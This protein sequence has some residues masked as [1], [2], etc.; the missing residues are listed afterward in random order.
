MLTSQ[1]ETWRE[2]LMSVSWFMR[3]LNEHI[4]RMA[5]A[6]DHCTGRF[7]EG[8]FKCQALLDESA[9]AACMAYVDLN[10][11]RAKMAETPEA[12]DFTSVRR[13]IQELQEVNPDCSLQLAELMP[14]AG[15]PREPMPDGLPF[16]LRDYLQLVEWTGRQLREDKR[17]SIPSSL[18]PLLQRLRIE[19]SAW[20][21]MTQHFERDFK[22]WI[23]HSDKIATMCETQ[24]RSWVQGISA[25]RRAFQTR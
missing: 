21:T 25:C 1:V 4:A 5:N 7:W 19:P 15:N 11:I 10:P 6:E 12:S 3:C 14:F 13:R 20:L 22:S 17:G 24:G 23:G 8:R 9:L 2:R 18:L 16:Q